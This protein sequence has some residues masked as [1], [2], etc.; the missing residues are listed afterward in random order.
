[1]IPWYLEL[2]LDTDMGIEIYTRLC[3]VSKQKVQ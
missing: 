1:M 3:E 2:D